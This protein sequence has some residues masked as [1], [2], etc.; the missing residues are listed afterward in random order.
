MKTLIANCVLAFATATH[1]Q[2]AYFVPHY[3]ISFRYPSGY[4]LLKGELPEDDTG[5][6]YL[7]PIPMEFVAPGGERLATVEA[8]NGSYSGTDFVNSFVTI[9]VNEYLTSEECT[10]LP[11][12]KETGKRSRRTLGGI[13]FDGRQVFDGA[14]NHHFSGTVYHAYVNGLCYEIGAGVANA[15]LGVVDGM[16]PYPKRKVIAILDGI[17][18]SVRLQPR[19]DT[20]TNSPSI[21]IFNLVLID[22]ERNRYRIVWQV[23]GAQPDDIRLTMDCTC[24]ITA[25][26][27][28]GTVPTTLQKEALNR[29]TAT[30]GSFEVELANAP[31]PD[32]RLTLRLFVAGGHAV[33]RVLTITVPPL[34][35]R[36]D[37]GDPRSLAAQPRPSSGPYNPSKCP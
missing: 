21:R 28:S 9:S 29:I 24:A 19:N 32:G 10:A 26:P 22:R 30:T 14:M 12:D 23:A 5:L 37:G 17:L 16:K 25:V 20:N 13:V 36:L 15:G 6:G 7:G 34:P 18:S 2:Q 8:L 27:E 3:G 35:F 31:G 33:A 1:A 4:R 11:D